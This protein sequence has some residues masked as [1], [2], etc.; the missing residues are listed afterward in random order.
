[1]NYRYDKQESPAPP[2]QAD[3]RLRNI[4]HLPVMAQEEVCPIIKHY[5]DYLENALA[6]HGESVDLCLLQEMLQELSLLLRSGKSR[7]RNDGYLRMLNRLTTIYAKGVRVDNDRA[8]AG[9]A[10]NFASILESV[11]HHFQ[12]YDY[13]QSVS[14]L[15]H[16]M[17]RLFNAREESWLE[18][19]DH[20]LS[21]PNSI[22]FI[23]QLKSEYLGE[24]NC[25]IERG[26][27]NLF[28]LWDEQLEVLAM[29]SQNINE[30]ELQILARQAYLVKSPETL[31]SGV[32]DFRQ[33]QQ[34]QEIRTL[35]NQRKQLMLER[36]AKQEVVTLLQANV[37][38]FAEQLARMR[39]GALL[40][41]VW[42]NPRRTPRPS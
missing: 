36:Q 1:M 6:G 18:V 32:I 5:F 23:Q 14:L 20:L 38:E 13:H 21:M 33:L 39:R 16:Y 15:M 4:E 22:H 24:I 37:R 17:G 31:L 10:A 29:Q 8:F 34:Q 26:V 40:K 2:K 19:Y 11:S 42:D 7:I 25:W 9:T 12:D 3:F 35:S 30:L 27:D 41:L 28:T